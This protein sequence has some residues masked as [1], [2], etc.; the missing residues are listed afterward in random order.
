MESIRADALGFAHEMLRTGSE[1][2]WQ[3]DRCEALGG[4]LRA[5]EL[6]IARRTLACE[7]LPAGLKA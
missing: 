1:A 2:E 6:E 3:V 4:D 5:L 7:P